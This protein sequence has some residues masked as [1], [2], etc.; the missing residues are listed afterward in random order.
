VPESFDVPNHPHP[1]P[2][3]EYRERGWSK[4][5]VFAL[6]A[7]LLLATGVRFYDLTRHPIW[8]DE[9]FSLQHSAGRGGGRLMLA[10][11][12]V[13][14]PR[15]DLVG[16]HTRAPYPEI[17][18]GLA[19]E[20]ADVHPPLFPVVFRIWR[21][22]TEPLIGQ[23][24]VMMRTFSV[25]FG[26]ASVA[27][28]FD[29]MRLLHGIRQAIWASLIMSLAMPMVHYAQDAR[30]YTMAF[31]LLLGA[32]DAV[33]RLQLF[34]PSLPRAI[35]LGLCTL[36]VSLTHYYAIPP[37]AA[38]GVYALLRL[39]GRARVQASSA[40]LLAMT[41]FLVMWWPSLRIQLRGAE[42]H[43]AF[44]RDDKPGHLG[45]T[46]LRVALLPQWSLNEP[47]SS[48]TSLAVLGAVI[49][50]LPL[51]LLRRRPE[52]LIWAL[53]I[54]GAL[55]PPL[56]MDL[57]HHWKQLDHLRYA[58]MVM[59]GVYPLIATVL[60]GAH[61]PW[62]RHVLPAMAVL[63]CLISL[64]QTYAETETPKPDYPYLAET[65]KDFATPDDVI[66][67]YQSSDGYYQLMWYLALSWYA[68]DAM[69]PTAVF[70]MGEPDAS[71]AEVIQRALVVWTV[72][73]PGDDLPGDALAGRVRAKQTF[74]FN[75]PVLAKWERPATTT[76][77]APKTAH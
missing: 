72:T 35:V 40:M 18:R 3:P 13:R 2:L 46:I 25:L 17:W 66:V 44:L 54:A 43:T 73:M 11:S 70:V 22:V 38:L 48:A 19:A 31:T 61:R 59:L 69:P 23:T 53:W 21:D 30:P 37:L 26:V 24:D 16:L 42:A 10:S 63:S 6:L 57:R 62:M 76:T 36:A 34:G 68:R 51:L 47:P 41:I 75:L 71:A 52:L 55:A 15:P 27:L 14:A 56:F 7:I 64:P 9:Y 1:D 77:S 32:I 12:G 74:G 39:R 28:M 20:N 4:R 58:S 8:L 65:L 67:F 50:V 45:R 60:D 29:V 49:Y 5:G 33:V